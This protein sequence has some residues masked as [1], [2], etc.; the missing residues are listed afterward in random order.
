MISII[1]KNSFG[2]EKQRKMKEI[3]VVKKM[4]KE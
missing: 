2:L 1:R 3:M 4:P